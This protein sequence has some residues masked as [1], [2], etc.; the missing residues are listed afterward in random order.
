MQDFKRYTWGETG[1]NLLE[2]AVEWDGCPATP[3]VEAAG[4]DVD[5]ELVRVGMLT[6]PWN[7]HPIGA[8]VVSD[9]MVTGFTFAVSDTPGQ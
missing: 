2:G 7:G 4:L 5:D 3:Y 1:T 6:T 9:F 8:M